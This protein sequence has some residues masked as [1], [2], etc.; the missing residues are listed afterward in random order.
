MF[1][2]NFQQARFQLRQLKTMVLQPATDLA[3]AKQSLI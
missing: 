3:L 2:A 1:G